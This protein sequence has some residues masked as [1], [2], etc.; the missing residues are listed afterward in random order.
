MTRSELALVRLALSAVLAAGCAASTGGR[1]APSSTTSAKNEVDTA[2]AAQPFAAS[3]VVYDQTHAVYWLAD[4]NVAATMYNNGDKN[5]AAF[6]QSIAPCAAAKNA[7]PSGVSASG[8][9]DLCTANAFVQFL[10][11]YDNGPNKRKGYLSHQ[12]WQLPTT[13]TSDCTCSPTWGGP[14]GPP[15]SC[16]H[17]GN[18]FGFSCFN[19]DMGWLFY[20]D[21]LKNSSAPTWPT[22]TPGPQAVYQLIEAGPPFKNAPLK[23]LQPSVYWGQDLPP[24]GAI[25]HG[26]FSFANGGTGTNVDTNFYYVL[27]M[28]HD[29]SAPSGQC[30]S[31]NPPLIAYQNNSLVYDCGNKL[32]W[33]ADANYAASLVAT[34]QGPAGISKDGAMKFSIAFN[35]TNLKDTSTLIGWMNGQNNPFPNNVAQWTLPKKAQL[36]KLFGELP[37]KYQA[38]DSV[39]TTTEKLGPTSSQ[40]SR[41]QPYLYW[42]TPGGPYVCE[43]SCTNA[44]PCANSICNGLHAG[45]NQAPG[46]CQACQPS[47]SGCMCQDFAFNFEDGFVD[48]TDDD[49]LLYVMVYYHPLPAT[50][51]GTPAEC[52]TKAG[53][54]WNANP[55]PGSCACGNSQ[56]CCGQAGYYWNPDPPPGHCE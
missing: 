26:T 16:G 5:F 27:P 49:K 47:G 42:S 1:P 35:P 52:C 43:P 14:Q 19:S 31:T 22:G 38:G 34:S 37:N 2:T 17:Q 29:P 33:L 48:T 55:P 45:T 9:M 23:N 41:V 46:N 7:K 56:K 20:T 53:G 54:H 21:F 18:T 51:C 36:Q 50:G 10:N 24:P 12:N 8:T 4:A 28:G 32:T 6:N 39:L 30:A 40:F 13:P 11:T 3:Q 15:K 25:G 44:G